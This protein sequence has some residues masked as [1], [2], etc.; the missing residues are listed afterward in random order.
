MNAMMKLMVVAVL[1]IFVSG[2]WIIDLFTGPNGFKVRTTFTALPSPTQNQL[3]FPDPNVSVS[4]V[5]LFDNAGS[6]CG[7]QFSFDGT[8]NSDGKLSVSNGR[9]PASWRLARFG[10]HTG[11][12]RLIVS[13]PLPLTCGAEVTINCGA[14][15]VFAM[16]P[17]AIDVNAPPPTASFTGQ[18]LDT[19]YGMPT[20][21]FY[22]EYGTYFAQTAATA[23]SA[24]GTWLQTPV[25]SLA[26]LYS[27]TYTIV[28][29]NAT[30]DGSRNAIGSATVWL[31]GNDMPPPP[32][33]PLPDP[34]S[35]DSKECQV[36]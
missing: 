33:D 36:Y 23:V 18:G 16:S 12:D 10:G 4:G 14:G 24:D 15:S 19:T 5:W 26:G 35:C 25:P 28:I 20:L 29:V 21:E 27:G 22:D 30:A 32:P 2:C 3:I 1:G 17:D 11:C 9:V 8:T 34:G 6:R 13:G 7:E 31:Y